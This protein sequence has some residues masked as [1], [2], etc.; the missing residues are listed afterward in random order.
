MKEGAC[1]LPVL[2]CPRM[3]PSGLCCRYTILMLSCR[4]G[5][6]SEKTSSETV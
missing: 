2:S 6:V 4:R 5:L 1:R 3:P